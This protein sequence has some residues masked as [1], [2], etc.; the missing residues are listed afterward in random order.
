LTTI[1]ITHAVGMTVAQNGV[2]QAL[3]YLVADRAIY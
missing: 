1:T 3:R 2:L